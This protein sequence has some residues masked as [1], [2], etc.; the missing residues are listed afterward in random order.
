MCFVIGFF[1]TPFICTIYMAELMDKMY[2]TNKG[3]FVKNIIQEIK[4]IAKEILMFIPVLIITKLITI[5]VMVG[6]P[7]NQINI[8]QSF[9]EMPI[10]NSICAIVIVPIVEEVV[11]R[12]LP[13]KFIK[14]KA[15]YIIV[16]TVIFAVMHVINDPN[17][18]YYVW[19]YMMRPLYY[20]YS[21]YRTKDILVP[22]SM[23]SL[24]NL[25][26]TLILVF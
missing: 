11:F 10:F 20:G 19:F 8:E 1:I 26:E 25:I 15:V 9:F 23:H 18:C 17:A 2:E 24:N 12:L 6:Q 16:S 13:Y 14:N 22:I 3:K 5:F 21:Y 7:V 4:K